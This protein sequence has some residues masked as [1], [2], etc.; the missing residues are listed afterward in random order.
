MIV[1]WQKL[2]TETLHA[3]V[4]AFVL[5]EGTDYGEREASM[6][7]KIDHVMKRLNSNE[8][9]VVFDPETE[10]CDLRKLKEIGK[11]PPPNSVETPRRTNSREDRSFDQSRSSDLDFDQSVENVFPDPAD[12]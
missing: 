1:P 8:V 3:L 9:A 5:R 2:K 7:T 10:T 11:T 4:E 6:D 12:H